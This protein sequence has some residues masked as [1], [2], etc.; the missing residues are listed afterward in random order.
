M[1]FWESHF[2]KVMN[3]DAFHKGY[4]YSFRHMYGK[5]G[6]RKNYTPY[7]CLKIIMGTPPEAGAFHGCP[8]RHATDSQL[9]GLLN[10]LKLSVPDAKEVIGIA[11]SG[12][13][14]L[15]CQ[16]HFDITHPGHQIVSALLLACS[17]LLVAL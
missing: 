12:N 9:A 10:G 8:Y 11:K 16:K 14:Q 4:A 15:A 6:A 2:T 17:L 1:L 13:Y 5:E 3:H 7:S